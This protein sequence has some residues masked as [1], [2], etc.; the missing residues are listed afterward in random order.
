MYIRSSMDLR[1]LCDRATSAA[2]MALDVEFIREE[3]YVPQLALIQMAVEDVCAIIDPLAVDDLAPLRDLIGS[4]DVLKVLHAPTQDLEILYWHLGR[5]PVHLFDTQTAAALVGLGEQISYGHLVKRLLHMTLSKGESYSRWMQ[6]PLTPAQI[7]Y[8]LD[9]VRY[10]LPLH[11]LLTAR[12]EEMERVVWAHEEFRKFENPELYLREP[13]VLLRRIRRG[14]TLGPESLAILR[15]LVVWRDREA[16]QRDKPPGSV[17]RDDSLVALARKA[18]RTLHDLSHLRSLPRRELDRSGPALIAAIQRGMAVAEYDRPQ[19]ISRPHL[20]RT[21]ELIVKFLDAYLK[22]LCQQQKVAAS[23]VAK[24]A[25][26]ECLVAAYRHGK[27]ASDG[28][29]LLEGWRRPLVG[30][31]L[32]AVLEGRVSLHIDSATGQVEKSPRQP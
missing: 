29:P 4:P 8:A 21:E 17:L 32:L 15:E 6:R 7:A 18:P 5:L 2:R 24:R 23:Y 9:D 31:E 16:Q 3:T 28:G 19:P 1:R 22:T 25:D 14:R 11:E 10:L 26:L 27:L 30:E 12:L 13:G 20:S